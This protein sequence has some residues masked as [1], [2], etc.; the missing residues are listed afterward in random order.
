MS[1]PGDV[2]HESAWG[3]G[4]TNICSP[5]LVWTWAW[6]FEG[7][8]KLRTGGPDSPAAHG[9][10]SPNLHLGISKLVLVVDIHLH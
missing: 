5:F 6:A 1:H 8:A 10:N 3:T 2:V 4:E 7:A 9:A